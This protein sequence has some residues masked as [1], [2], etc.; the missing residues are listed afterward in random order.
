MSNKE[1]PDASKRIKKEKQEKQNAK[2]EEKEPEESKAEKFKSLCSSFQLFCYNPKERSCLSRT[3]ME[4]LKIMVFILFNWGCIIAFTTIC[5]YIFMLIQ[6]P[7]RDEIPV[8]RRW[9]TLVDPPNF[10]QPDLHLKHAPSTCPLCV[11]VNVNCM[12]QWKPMLSPIIGKRLEELETSLKETKSH[13]YPDLDI[14]YVTCKG[15]S[16]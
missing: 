9:E 6:H 15:K 4:W 16:K 11:S 7:N 5:W 12:Y 8:W 1:D 10:I 13:P 2:E 14:M 3:A